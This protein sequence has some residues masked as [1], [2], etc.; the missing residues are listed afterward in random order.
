M[1]SLVELLRA[2]P[3]GAALLVNVYDG[4]NSRPRHLTRPTIRPAWKTI[5]SALS[6]GM[7]GADAYIMTMNFLHARAQWKLRFRRLPSPVLSDDALVLTV[8]KAHDLVYFAPKALFSPAMIP[9][10]TGRVDESRPWTLDH[11]RRLLVQFNSAAL[12][13]KK[14]SLA[15]G[16]MKK[17]YAHTYRVFWASPELHLRGLNADELRDR[18]GLVDVESG[19]PIFQFEFKLRHRSPRRHSGPTVIEA[20]THRRFRARPTSK[21]IAGTGAATHLRALREA[22]TLVDGAPELCLSPVWMSQL[23]ATWFCG[24]TTTE[25][26]ISPGRA[27]TASTLRDDET[28]HRL[29]LKG[30]DFD[31]ICSRLKY[32]LER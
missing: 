21:R 3:R 17:R 13:G 30:R 14:G 25:P 32:A 4:L 8:A 27:T 19:V 9:I 15:R 2:H 11:C 31:V 20:T 24:F 10:V 16:R 7:T 23:R 12:P 22:L 6:P 29:L 18:L 26:D 28:F 1:I 5:R